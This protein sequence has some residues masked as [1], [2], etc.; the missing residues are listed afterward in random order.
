MGK[1]RKREN[2]MALGV[3]LALALFVAVLII[4]SAGTVRVSGAADE[5]GVAATRQAI[6]R[7]AVLCYATE[8]FYPPSLGYIEERYGVQVDTDRY[9]VR[10]EVFAPNV[11]PSVVVKPRGTQD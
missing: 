10:Y 6:E 4:V 7:A 8:G 5:E 3:M 11:T 1:N 2:G 9:A